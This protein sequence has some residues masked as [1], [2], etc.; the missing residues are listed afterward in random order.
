MGAGACVK[1]HS[2][3]SEE[4]RKLNGQK[5]W[6][7]ER[8]ESTN[9]W[10]VSLDGSGEDGSIKQL[11]EENLSI[12]PMVSTFQGCH[13]QGTVRHFYDG[14]D[15]SDSAVHGCNRLLNVFSAFAGG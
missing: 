8:T 7:L 14:F 15:A 5:G 11:K 12:V 6:L 13:P 10:R 2:L 4:G 3:V 1:V 9:L